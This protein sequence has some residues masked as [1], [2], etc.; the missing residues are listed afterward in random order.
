MI[1]ST[2]ARVREMK[3][4]VRK[5]RGRHVAER[6]AR[7]RE[8]EEHERD[9][10]REQKE[11]G[12]DEESPPSSGGENEVSAT[13]ALD[14]A[15]KISTS[16]TTNGKSV[17]FE[18]VIDMESPTRNGIQVKGGHDPSNLAEQGLHQRKFMPSLAHSKP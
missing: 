18:D 3:D 6:N 4:E 15:R 17:T 7:R 14:P 1:R 2:E 16:N 8:K 5:M 10:E 11:G 12:E 9:L 13:T